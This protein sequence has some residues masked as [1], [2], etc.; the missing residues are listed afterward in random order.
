MRIVSDDE[1]FGVA[2]YT[3]KGRVVPCQV[4]YVH[5]NGSTLTFESVCKNGVHGV[6]VDW[7]GDGVICFPHDRFEAIS[8]L[9]GPEHFLR[10]VRA[11][12]QAA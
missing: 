2:G 7:D 12:E 8:A 10:R 6:I 1:T 3:T 9:L 4:K 11:A 5:P